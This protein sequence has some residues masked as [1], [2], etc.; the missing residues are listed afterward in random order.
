MLLDRFPRFFATVPYQKTGVPISWNERLVR[1]AVF[2]RRA[3]AKLLRAAVRSGL[4]PRYSDPHSYTDYAHWLR[5]DPAR[6]F[7]TRLLHDA[8][9]L[10]PEWIPR[11]RVLPVWERHLRGEDQTAMIGRYVTVELFMQQAFMQRFRDR[12][13]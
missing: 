10:Y 1:L 6:T 7:I 12:P 2:K 11:E 4:L 5:L 3:T 8:S 9:A 13:E